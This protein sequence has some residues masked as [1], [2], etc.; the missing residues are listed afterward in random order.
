MAYNLIFTN[1][2]PPGLP[3]EHRVLIEGCTPSLKNVFSGV[4]QG[5]STVLWLLMFLLYINNI[6]TNINSSIHLFANDC[7][8]YKV[9]KSS[10]DH[11]LLQQDLNNLVQWADTWQMKLNIEKCVTMTCT[12][13]SAPIPIVYFINKHPLKIIDQHDYLGVRLHSSMTWSHHI[14]C[15]VNKAT[16]DLNFIKCI[17]HKCT[18]EVKTTAY[19]T[20]VRPLLEYAAM[21]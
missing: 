11:L 7:V 20:L 14:Q 2:L 15:K 6:Y 4:P 19:F 18:R 21:V 3:L 8:L 10:Q 16:K 17:L 9:I 5:T 1:G 13:S 12:K